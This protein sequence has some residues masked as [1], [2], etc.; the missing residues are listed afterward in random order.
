MR[1]WQKILLL[2][3]ICFVAAGLF[4]RTMFREI[5]STT[6]GIASPAILELTLSG[7][8]PER[9]ADD[10]FRDALGEGAFVTM[11]DALKLIRNAKRDDRIK[12]LVLRPMGMVAG[13]AKTDE[14]RNALL[15]FKESGKPLYAYLDFA[16]EREYYLATVADTIVGLGTGIWNVNGF[17]ARPTFFKQTLEKIGVKA[18]FV[19]HKEYKNAPDEYTR[20]SMSAQ[21]R[22][23]LNT[24]VDQYYGAFFDTLSANLDMPTTELQ[25]HIDTGLFSIQKAHELGFVDT[26]MY[27]ES[28]KTHLE[29]QFDKKPKFVGNSAYGKVNG[30][31]LGITATETVAVIYGVGSIIGGGEGLYRQGEFITSGGMSKAV[32]DAAENDDI[33][34]I[35][36]RLDSPGGSGTASDIIWQEIMEARKKKP[37]IASISDMAASG[38]YYLA[39]AAD[40]IIAH[41]HS[42]VGSIGI[43]AGK[44]SMGELYEKI[45]ITGETVSRGRNAAMFSD[46]T[47][48]TPEQ[49]QIMSDFLLE[50]YNDFVNKVAESRGMTPENAESLAKGRVWTGSEGKANGLV[51]ELGDFSDAIRIAKEMSGIPLDDSVKLAIYPRLESYFERLFS[52]LPFAIDANIELPP[53]VKLPP[54]FRQMLLAMPHFQPGEPLFWE[55]NTFETGQQ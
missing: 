31:D 33:K 38:G 27:Y 46:A 32:R 53:L 3:V 24:I 16:G 36:L 26:L 37:V 7:T 44:F 21:Q 23:I 48:F 20:E 9:A 51:D 8:I 4:Y 35:I 55:I 49:R 28:F 17:A 12:A 41:P 29:N 5:S 43:Y 34:A 52:S 6:T 15:S 47:P 11:Q 42:L 45:G 19:A 50:F 18:D 1:E 39:M 30:A 10:P 2:I 54:H 13:W 25:R 14:I 22:Q 40:T